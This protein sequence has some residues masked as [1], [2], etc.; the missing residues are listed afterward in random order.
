MRRHL[1]L[2]DGHNVIFAVPSL[3]ALQVTDRRDEARRALADR[4]ERFA[5]ARGEKVLIVFDGAG[6]PSNP[7]ARRG[8]LIEITYTRPAEGG[9]DNRIIYLASQCAEQRL[10]VTVVTDDISTLAG[11]LPRAV[12]HLGVSEFWLK[13][14][15]RPPAPGG[16]RV[17]G[18]F[19]DVEGELLEYSAAEQ[20]SAARAASTRRRPSAGPG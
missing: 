4:L 1:W 8:S 10:P 6:L 17:E 15:D 12:V 20:A 13:H 5:H 14:I 9:A 2:I 16:K 11:K 18:D 19:S 3:R 7:D